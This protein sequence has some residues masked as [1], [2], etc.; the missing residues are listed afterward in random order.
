MRLSLMTYNIRS[1]RGADGIV[2]PARI[3][4]VVAPLRPDVLALQEVDLDLPRSS[5]ADQSRVLAEILKMEYLFHP[6]L[7]REKGQYG[8]AVLSRFPLRLV[9][10]GRLPARPGWK[11]REERG[12]LWTEVRADG[13]PVQVINTHLGLGWRERF[14]QASALLGPEWLGHP[15]CRAPRILCGDLNA[16]P[17]SRVCRMFRRYLRDAQ[18]GRGR[19]GDRAGWPSRFPVTRLDY[20]FT[21]PGIVVAGA[22][23]PRDPPVSA[24]SDHLPLYVELHLPAEALPG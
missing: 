14:A 4:A 13:V 21:S 6:A 24:A 3:A 19:A 7:H 16:L 2:S 11:P 17:F 10:G 12:A 22:R 15:D 18:L 20:V 1:C 5:H 23:V 8:N 9:R